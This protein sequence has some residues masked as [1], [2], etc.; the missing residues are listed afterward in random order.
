MVSALQPPLQREMPNLMPRLNPG[1]DTT[2][3]QHMEV[4]EVTEVTD[5][6]DGADGTD[7]TGN[8]IFFYYSVRVSGLDQ[9]NL[10]W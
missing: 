2:D 1:G 9:F 7:G 8:N 6:A 4:G 3:I 10:V 5:G